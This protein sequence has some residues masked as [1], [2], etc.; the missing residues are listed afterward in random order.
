LRDEIWKVW[1]QINDLLNGG[2]FEGDGGTINYGS[3]IGSPPPL[4]LIVLKIGR[5]KTD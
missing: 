3:V 5:K 1:A 2:N 4:R